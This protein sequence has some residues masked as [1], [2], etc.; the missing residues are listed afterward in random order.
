MS[1][2]LVFASTTALVV[3]LGV[4]VAPVTLAAPAHA[5]PSRTS[6]G[7]V[8]GVAVEQV[9]P[10]SI[11][12][13]SMRARPADLL[14]GV[15]SDDRTRLVVVREEDG[16]PIVETITKKGKT[17][18][19]KE[20]RRQQADPDVIAVEVDTPVTLLEHVQPNRAALTDPRRAELWG[21]DRLKVEDAWDLADGSGISVAVIDTGV[22]VHEDLAGVVLPGVDLSGSGGSGRNDGHG[23]GTHV[24][25]TIAA[26]IDNGMGIAGVAPQA[27]IIPV[28]VLTD[29]GT[30]NAGTVAEGII[31][32]TNAGADIINMSLGGT[33]PSAASE[34]AVRYAVERGVVVVAAAGNSGT[35]GSPLS[36][37]A[38]YPG[39]L[40]VGATN[41]ADQRASFSS[42]N[43]SVDIAAPGAAILLSLIHI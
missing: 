17:A 35:F 13:E 11:E 14:G 21:L 5:D 1:K 20:I 36:Y 12:D 34:I 29:Q 25:G 16:S 27:Q 41:S 3:G 10:W 30:G 18:A 33:I 37:P 15:R 8:P 38:S 7:L 9:L 24:A 40:A 28:K 39:V 22:A 2:S 31:W 32:A 19:A 26:T 23:H 43:A 4:W 6:I 42:A